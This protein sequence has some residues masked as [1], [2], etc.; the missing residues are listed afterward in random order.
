[1]KLHFEGKTTKRRKFINI[2]SKTFV[3]QLQN[4]LEK[5]S[6]WRERKL[7]KL[8]SKSYIH[9]SQQPTNSGEKIDLIFLTTQNRH[10]K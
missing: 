10:C 7:K 6:P 8:P 2:E 5:Y 4:K 3:K 1:M 9:V